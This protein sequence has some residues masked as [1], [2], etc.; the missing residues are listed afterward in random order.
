MCAPEEL[1]MDHYQ[2]LAKVQGFFPS[3]EDLEKIACEDITALTMAPGRLLIFREYFDIFR[4]R[5]ENKTFIADTDQHPNR[6]SSHGEVFPVQLTHGMFVSYRPR[7]QAVYPRIVLGIEHLTAQGFH[8][9]RA[10]CED[11]PRSAMTTILS[12]LTPHE[13]KHLSGNAMH[14]PLV[15]SW[16]VMILANIVRL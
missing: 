2:E 11:V 4:R 16:M 9:L 12:S 10:T 7:G 8:L 6:A 5:A 3:R 14:V 1:V 15:A 13:Q